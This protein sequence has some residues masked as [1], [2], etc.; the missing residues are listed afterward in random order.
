MRMYAE[1][2]RLLDDHMTTPTFLNSPKNHRG[3][4]IYAQQYPHHYSPGAL[5]AP[6][7]KIMHWLRLVDWW[8]G[9][10]RNSRGENYELHLEQDWL[11]V[12][13]FWGK[14]R[15]W[16]QWACPV[17]GTVPNCWGHGGE[18]KSSCLASWGFH[19]SGRRQ[20][21]TKHT[22]YFHIVTGPWRKKTCRN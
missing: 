21:V 1:W 17:S 5:C 12:M 10:C 18:H 16:N 4:Q 11:V 7:W 8:G 13:K 6:L 19:S 20:T 3:L 14:L 2:S 22:R 15:K 9:N